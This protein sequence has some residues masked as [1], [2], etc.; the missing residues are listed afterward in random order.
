MGFAGG[1]LCGDVR[2]ECSADASGIVYCHC[3]N[4]QIASG[5]A[6]SCNVMVPPDSITITSGELTVYEDTADSGNTVARE[7]C[8]RCGSAIISRPGPHMA[9]IKAG[10]LD[11]P[12]GLQAMMSIWEDSAQPWALKAEGLTTFGKNPG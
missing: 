12:S 4:C 7:F 1:C 9:V 2:Y 10:S 11:D 8:G 6:F 5:T 3:R